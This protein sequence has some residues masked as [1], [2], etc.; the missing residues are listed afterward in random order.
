MNIT[1]YTLQYCPYC[2]YALKLLDQYN[3]KYKNIIV[4]PDDK[5]KIKKINNMDTFPM[6]F[7]KKNKNNI[8][9]G[10]SSDLL[11]LINI[12]EDIKK[13]NLDIN[14][15]YNFFNLLYPK[16]KKKL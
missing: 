13:S 10:G 8:K 2:N 16:S 1:I 6:I 5:N 4:N 3:I 11:K 12:S 14:I 7:I 9:I 15:I